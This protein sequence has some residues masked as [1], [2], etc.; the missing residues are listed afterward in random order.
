MSD[1]IF[2]FWGGG[3]LGFIERLC[4]TS[5]VN[6]GHI[7]DLYSF[8]RDLQAPDGVNVRSA[9]NVISADKTPKNGFGS[10]AL[11]ADIFRYHGLQQNAGIWL[12]LDVV[13][14]K[15]LHG[16][17]DHIFGW[18]DEGTINNAVLCL[19]QNS[20]CLAS[21]LA[22]SRASPFIAPHWR[23]RQKAI[24]WLRGLVGK[25][26]PVEKAEWGALG[27]F[28]LTYYVK[29]TGLR[30]F[31]QP[32]EVFYPVPFDKASTFF[33]PDPGYVAAR[34]TP[35]TRA[36][37]LWNDMIKDLKKQPPHPNSFI[38]RLCEQYE[39]DPD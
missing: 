11:F 16:M 7:V 14:I 36:V 4:L 38:G 3:R 28:A 27:P 12:D 25:D 33:E 31:S 30:Q 24:Q 5:M 23:R 20:A 1:R 35:N 29:N 18:Q 26:L 8:D 13:L 32:P 21:L 37:H 19:P 34:I 10:W 39:I 15:P 17:D 2:T 22:L 6:A 9:D